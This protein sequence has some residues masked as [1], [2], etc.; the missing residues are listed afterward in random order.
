[1]ASR[2]TLNARNLEALGAAALAE[3]LMEV[4]CG[5]AVIQRR[6]RLALAAAE[7]AEGA[8]REVRKR[9][10]AIDR[11]TTSV[12]SRRRQALLT[13]LEAQHQAITGPIAAADPGQAL[14][15]LV[16]FLELADGVLERSSDTTGAVI[17]VFERALSDLGPVAAAAGR[18]PEELAEQVAELI[19]AN[20]YGQFDGLI[21]AVASALGETGLAWLQRH[22]EAHGGADATAALLQIAEACGDVDAYMAQ[23]DARKL[24][25][26]AVA[27]DVA[28]HLLE[29]ERA[30]QALAVLD[31]AAA[32]V[33]DWF[34]VEWSDAR[35][36][37]LEA[38]GRR[39]DAQE[40][41]WQLFCR[42]LSIPH[43]RSYLKRIDDFADVEAEERALQ[44][45][46]RH[47]QP[48]LALAFLTQWPALSRAA[49]LVHQHCGHWDGEAFEVCSPAAERLSTAH[50]LAA[51]I[52]LR[53]MV[54][55]AL[56]SGRSR[57]YRYAAEHLQTCERLAA[58]IDDWQGLD[59]Q[60]SF[61]GR[62]R[63]SF[64]RNRS[65][66]Q[67]VER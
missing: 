45:A 35:I 52:L 3:L 34:A 18:N 59:S 64:G 36:T 51:I 29:A 66:W 17:G 33:T 41:R 9:L 50:P 65:F 12:D 47:A 25:R 53:S 30:E 15:L 48:L 6:L 1:M 49:R 31:G 56:S 23:F 10:T 27:T 19:D 54:L 22:F 13:D 37:V 4:S 60:A 11:A 14:Q 2:R 67:L 63:E 20:G 7:G 24:S 39:D 28:L 58:E 44:V 26:P 32:N 46:E 8:A 38:L 61:L 40:Q 55:F 62:L 43:L 16:R 21:P 42:S 5:H 57:R